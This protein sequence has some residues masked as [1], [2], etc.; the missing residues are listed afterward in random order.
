MKEN[1]FF[2]TSSKNAIIYVSSYPKQWLWKTELNVFSYY[3]LLEG[4]EE[5]YFQLEM[6]GIVNEHR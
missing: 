1:T 6:L 4:W 2:S 5:K 3:S